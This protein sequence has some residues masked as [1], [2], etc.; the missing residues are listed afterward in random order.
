MDD[1]NSTLP[2][3]QAPQA[4]STSD[5]PLSASMNSSNQDTAISGFTQAQPKTGFLDVKAPTRKFMN[6]LFC[7]NLVSIV[8]P[9][10]FYAHN[11]TNGTDG[12]VLLSILLIPLSIFLI[13]PTLIADL[14]YIPVFLIK[15]K[16][17]AGYAIVATLTLLLPICLLLGYA[18]LR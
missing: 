15:S 4:Q 11:F 9:L 14:I 5:V 7:L 3:T 13:V 1:K 6:I 2:D 8:L 16:P 17:S 10:L 18:I 12:S